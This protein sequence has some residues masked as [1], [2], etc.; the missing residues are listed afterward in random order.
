MGEPVAEADALEG[1]RGLCLVRDA[2]KILGEHH[3]F[4]SAQVG[5]QVELLKDEANFFGAVANQVVFGEFG[6]V[7]PVDDHMAR[8]QGIQAA[9]NIDQSGLAGAGWPHERDPFAGLDVEGDAVQ[10]AQRP[11]LLHQRFNAHLRVHASPRKTLAGRTLANRRRGNALAMETRM[12]MPTETGYTI[13]RGC[14]ATPKTAFPSQMEPK[15]PK[16]EPMRPP[17]MP[18]NIA[19]ARNKR[20]TR[21][22]EPPIAFIKPTSFL[23]S[24]ATLLIPAMPHSE[25][26][27]STMT[28]G[29]VTRPLLRC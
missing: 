6:Q 22:T 16:A 26:G 12:V 3:V 13:Q 18:I 2:V 10:R 8:G 25:G 21:R 29:P 9:E 11:V 20:T 19:S 27:K 23:R 28:T 5:H 4:E 17:T 7:H 15:M 1:F 24:I 14:A